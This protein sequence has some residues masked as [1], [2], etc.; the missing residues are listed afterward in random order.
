MSVAV[1]TDSHL[2]GPGG[3]GDDFVEQLRSLPARGCRRLVLLGDIFHVWV[4]STKYETDEVRKIVP[5]L[6]RLR[7]QG[8]RIEYVEGNR[9]FYIGRS[10][11][12]DAFDAVV[13]ETT[14]TVGGR[15]YLCVHGDGLDERDWQYRFWRRAS[16]S[17]PIRSLV[18]GMPT[19]IAKRFV[20]GTE[21]KLAQTNQAHRGAL[22]EAAIRAYGGRRLGTAPGD[23]EADVLLLGHFHEPHEFVV[24]GGEIRLL[25]AWFHSHRVEWFED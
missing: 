8:L 3:S 7:E 14:F 25:D 16:K 23:G 19:S 6:R 24:E 15:R 9:D 11:Y 22:A 1:L 5:E 21:A 17:W 10:P 20:D 12:A 2:G 13:L 4:G 18:L